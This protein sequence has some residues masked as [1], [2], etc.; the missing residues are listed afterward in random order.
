MPNTL[1]YMGSCNQRCNCTGV[2]GWRSPDVW[3]TR[4]HRILNEMGFHQINVFQPSAWPLLPWDVSSLPHVSRL[5]WGGSTW[6]ETCSL[7]CSYLYCNYLCLRSCALKVGKEYHQDKLTK[8]YIYIY[9][10]VSK[11]ADKRFFMMFLTDIIKEAIQ[12]NSCL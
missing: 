4:I 3:Y 6:L 8:W 5:V 7:L 12:I 1:G 10:T 2:I 11:F 9:W